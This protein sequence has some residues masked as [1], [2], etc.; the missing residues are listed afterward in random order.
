MTKCEKCI[1]SVTRHRIVMCEYL[2]KT[3][4]PR[5]CPPGDSCDKYVERKE[6]KK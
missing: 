1:Y 2:M 4:V 5:G 6:V 3:G